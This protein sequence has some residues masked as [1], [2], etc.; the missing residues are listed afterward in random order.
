MPL[1]AL[2]RGRRCDSYRSIPVR[3]TVPC[4]TAAVNR[5]CDPPPARTSRLFTDLDSSLSEVRFAPNM[6]DPF[7]KDATAEQSA[8]CDEGIDHMAG[9]RSVRVDFPGHPIVRPADAE[10][11]AISGRTAIWPFGVMRFARIPYDALRTRLGTSRF[12]ACVESAT[13]PWN[14]NLGGRLY[15]PEA[16]FDRYVTLFRSP[17]YLRRSV[18]P[19]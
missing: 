8:T 18:V 7:L 1:M 3:V 19:C 14:R 5:V 11:T 2:T 13:F 12:K 4:C 9:S 17:E 10:S 15:A 16:F 6:V